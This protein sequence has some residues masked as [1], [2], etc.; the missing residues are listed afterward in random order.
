MFFS[1]VLWIKKACEQ[2]KNNYR[3]IDLEI[4]W[5]F[6]VYENTEDKMM[7]NIFQVSDFLEW[8]VK[9]LKIIR[10][11]QPRNYLA[12]HNIKMWREMN[13]IIGTYS[14][15]LSYRMLES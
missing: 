4:K 12:K 11:F 5:H 9:K 8:T 3:L 10:V 2:L 7:H 6:Q 13:T 1:K 14:C 15:L